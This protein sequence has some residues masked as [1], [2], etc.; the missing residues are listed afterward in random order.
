MLAGKPNPAT[1]P[2]QYIHLGVRSPTDKTKIEEIAI[3]GD[4]LDAALQYGVTTGFTELVEWV[5]DLAAQ[6]H[7]RDPDA[8]AWRVSLGPG[9]QDLLY[10]ALNA[11]VNPGDTVVVEGPTYPCV[12]SLFRGLCSNLQV[13]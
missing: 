5:K 1:F 10:K 8:E 6:V 9:S 7:G 2:F 3:Q 12:A 11:L 4:D 13:F